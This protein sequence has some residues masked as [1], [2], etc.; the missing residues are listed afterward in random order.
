MPIRPLD[1]ITS[2]RMPR[3]SWAITISQMSLSV[4][5]AYY[6]EWPA[7]LVTITLQ[8]EEAATIIRQNSYWYGQCMKR[9]SC[10]KDKPDDGNKLDSKG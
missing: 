3:G 6:E 2:G 5:N 1:E 10:Q 8:A 4:F 9:G 7:Y